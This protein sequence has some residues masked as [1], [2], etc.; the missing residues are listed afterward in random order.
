MKDQAAEVHSD[1][2]VEYLK[3]NFDKPITEEEF[4]AHMQLLKPFSK[5]AS[6]RARQKNYM[7]STLKAKYRKLRS[8]F[9]FFPEN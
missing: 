5:A 7:P 6:G 3:E 1:R 2:H 4:V 8:D 9:G